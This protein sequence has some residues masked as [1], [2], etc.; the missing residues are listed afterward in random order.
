MENDDSETSEQPPNLEEDDPIEDDRHRLKDSIGY[1]GRIGSALETPDWT[2]TPYIIQTLLILIAPALFAASVYMILGRIIRL[3]DGEKY[4]VIPARWLTKIFVTLDVIS[5][6][7]QGGG[8]GL[9]ASAND[10]DGL[11]RGQNIIMGGLAVQLIGFSVFIL[12]S[13]LFHWRILQNPT[14][15]SATSNAPWQRFLYV[16]YAVSV[17]I[18]I[19]SIF[20]IIEYGQGWDGSLQTFEAVLYI[21]D[22][23]LMLSAMILLNIWHPSRIISAA[24]DRK[25]LESMT[26]EGFRLESR[27][28]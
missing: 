9:L 23:L 19:R 1:G 6:L 8:G 18:L 2:L 27:Q 7:M 24:P 28:A 3:V 4:S 12:V 11:Q 20:R 25:S 26:E 17:L 21:F 5:F 16:L 14:S 22:G 10:A 15:T 13:I